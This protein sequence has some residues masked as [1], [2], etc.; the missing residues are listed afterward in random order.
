MSDLQTVQDRLSV[1]ILGGD[2]AYVADEFRVEHAAAAARLNIF[3][4]NTYTSL[5]ECL[6]TV[7]PVT[8]RLSDERFFAYAAHEFITKFPLR[9]ARLSKYGAEFPRFLASFEPCLDFP[10][11]AEMATLEWAIS[12]SLNEVEDEPI[13]IAQI[14]GDALSN[15]RIRLFLQL[16]F[17]F[18]ISRWPLAGVW[19]DHRKTNVVITGFLKQLV[20]R[21]A[22]WRH[23]DDFQILELDAAR[24]AFWRVLARGGSLEEAASRALLRDPLFDIVRETLILFRSN[25]VTAALRSN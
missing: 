7:F 19:S 22:I 23:G 8:V 15:G 18:T 1:A 10:I 25:L 17:R 16:N 5:T 13:T 11:I 2:M 21:V 14:G 20:S 12:E 3:R 6:K 24:F 9:D 4:N